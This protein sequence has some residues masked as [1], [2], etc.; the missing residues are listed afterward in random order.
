MENFNKMLDV[1]KNKGVDTP[2]TDSDTG[3]FGNVGA[4]EVATASN[5]E[6]L[7]LHLEGGIEIHIPTAVYEAMSSAMG[8][9]V[10]VPESPCM[11]GGPLMNTEEEKESNEEKKECPFEKK[12]DSNE[13]SDDEDKKDEE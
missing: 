8:G 3:S 9:G 5:E 1:I 7:V 10:E 2:D 4:E 6:K 11:G 12:E 13:K